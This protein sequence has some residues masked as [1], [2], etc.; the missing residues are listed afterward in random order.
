MKHDVIKN[1]KLEDKIKLCSGL[2]FWHTKPM[3]QYNIESI[4]MAD[5]PHGLRKQ[6]V[7]NDML[8]INR[9]VE[10][11]CFPTAAISACSFDVDLIG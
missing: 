7:A 1:M 9:S 11:T 4:M 5:G 8:G 10:A 2:D 6:E 3:E